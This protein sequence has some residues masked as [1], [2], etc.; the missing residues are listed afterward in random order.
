MTHVIICLVEVRGAEH[1]STSVV[2]RFS[3]RVKGGS[4]LREV[5]LPVTAAL[6]SSLPLETVSSTRTGYV[7]NLEL[8]EKLLDFII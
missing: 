2:R 6:S 5:G 8:L 7:V 1:T 4:G 3:K